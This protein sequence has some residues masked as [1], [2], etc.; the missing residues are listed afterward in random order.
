MDRHGHNGPSQ[1]LVSKHLEILKLGTENRLSKL[2]DGMAG[3]TVTGVTDRH[4]F[5]SENLVSELCDDLQD[6]P[7]QARRAVTGCVIPVWVGF[8]V[9]F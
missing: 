7:S 2:R 3:R 1:G 5:F 8:L 4:R 6:G 9:K